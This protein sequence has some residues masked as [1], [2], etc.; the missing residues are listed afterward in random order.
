MPIKVTTLQYDIVWENIAANKHKIEDLLNTQL[1]TE[2]DVII[3][4][5]MFTTGF[6]MNPN[7]HAETMQGETIA[8]LQLKSKQYNAVFCGSLIINYNGNFVNRFIAVEPNGHIN[9]YDKKHLFTKAG[10]HENF[11][12]G[13]KNIIFTVKGFKIRPLICYDIRFPIWCRNII[14]PDGTPTYDILLVVANWPEARIWHW[15]S[16]LIARAIENQSFV[17]AVN[18]I[19]IDGNE[20]EYNGCTMA[21]EPTGHVIYK[22]INK[23]LVYTTTFSATLLNEVRAQLPFLND[24]DRFNLHNNK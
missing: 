9:T 1:K 6:I 7:N 21:V 11:S 4:P 14:E 15:E 13:N 2:T 20:H 16:L 17:V 12:A 10:E 18:R 3:L 23:E 19:G 5:E 8:W 22:V 24:G